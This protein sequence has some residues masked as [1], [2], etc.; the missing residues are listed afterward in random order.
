LTVAVLVAALGV[1][2]ARKVGW[3][4]S[5]EE[6]APQDTVY[7]MLNAARAGNVKGY[8]A[9]CTGAMESGVRQ[10]L[11]ETSEVRF[12]QYLRDSNAKL[13]GVAVADPHIGGREAT[14]RV[15]YVYQDRNEAQ[16]MYLE[17]GPK[18]WKIARVDDDE[19]VKTLI[20]YG[21]PVK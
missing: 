19:R 13:K 11:A 6:A 17:K 18:G 9:T 1:G 15:E 4:L 12:A 10:T 3:R 5:R 21:T 16:R 7:A 14:V 8:L 20:P 2:A